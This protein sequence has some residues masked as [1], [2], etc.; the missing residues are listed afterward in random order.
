MVGVDEV[1]RLDPPSPPTTPSIR[2]QEPSHRASRKKIIHLIAIQNM[3]R[4]ELVV[5]IGVMS[6]ETVT[7]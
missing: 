3:D 2:E 6:A 1:P 5:W 7:D 4:S